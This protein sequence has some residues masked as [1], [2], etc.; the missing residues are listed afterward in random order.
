MI[1]LLWATLVAIWAPAQAEEP[2][3]SERE[4]TQLSTK[5]EAVVRGEV[6]AQRL[7][8]DHTGIWTIA[9]VRV[10]ETMQGSAPIVTEVRVPGGKLN[11]MEVM[12]ARAPRLLPG[13]E[14]LLFLKGDRIV[15]LDQGAFVVHDNQIWQALDPWTFGHAAKRSTATASLDLDRV[16]QAVN[17]ADASSDHPSSGGN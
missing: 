8:H 2:A 11:D 13:D 7:E 16:R 4:V 6:L 3:L 10:T 17:R 14:V 1:A 9:T 15:G 5:A 12:V